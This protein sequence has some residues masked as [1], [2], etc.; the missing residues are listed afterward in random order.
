MVKKATKWFEK[1]EV[2]CM[3][4][5]NKGG[6]QLA[7]GKKQVN[8][9]AMLQSSKDHH[10]K[11]VSENRCKPSINH[12][13]NNAEP[14]SLAPNHDGR[15]DLKVV[16]VVAVV[17]VGPEVV[18]VWMVVTATQPRAAATT[19][20]QLSQAPANAT[21]ATRSLGTSRGIALPRTMPHL[22]MELNKDMVLVCHP[23]GASF[24]RTNGL[25]VRNF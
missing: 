12:K 22:G 24:L 18:L 16:V 20:Q 15:S 2:F 7:D 14:S 3:Q 11:L 19:Q 6:P 25:V 5:H 17:V 1:C 8:H 10:G 21:I 4:A 9:E 23:A 13:T